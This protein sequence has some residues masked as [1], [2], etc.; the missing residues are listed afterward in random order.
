MTPLLQRN[1]PDLMCATE[2]WMICEGKIDVRSGTSLLGNFASG[3]KILATKVAKL[4]RSK[5]KP[6]LTLSDSDWTTARQLGLDA[7]AP[8]EGLSRLNRRKKLRYRDEED[9]RNDTDT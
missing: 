6:T 2:E 7:D 3:M 9:E 8:K 4:A 5:L 1:H